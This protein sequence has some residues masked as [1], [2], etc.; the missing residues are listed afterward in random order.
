MPH[1]RLRRARQ[2]RGEQIQAIA[3][4]TGVREHLLRTIDDGRFEELPRGVYGRAAIRA[5]AAAVGLPPVEVL[6]ECEPLLAPLDDPIA[7]LCRLQGLRVPSARIPAVEAAASA[8]AERP[9]G[10]VAAA[11]AIDALVVVG[12][13]LFVVVMTIT[14]F[15]LPVAAFGRTA[16]PAFAGTASILWICYVVFFGGIAGATPGEQIA[17][18]PAAAPDARPADLHV[19]ATRAWRCA[20]RDVWL[21]ER[22]GEWLGTAVATAHP[23]MRHGPLSRT[24]TR[25]CS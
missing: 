7:A 15:E 17:G 3:R 25:A 1:E 11:A 18:L 9:L 23:L 4:R 8:P 2:A 12:L 5:Y 14:A 24:D 20:C 10:R 19:V 16:A 22:L 21:I 6:A 13:L